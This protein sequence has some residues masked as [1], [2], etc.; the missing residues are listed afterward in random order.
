M[1]EINKKK[2]NLFERFANLGHYS[3]GSSAHSSRLLVS[4]LFGNNRTV[5]PLFRYLA[6]GYQYRY[7]CG[8]FSDGFFDPEITK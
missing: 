6:V 8:Y 4:S 2:K 3:H 1:V 7:Y 5:I